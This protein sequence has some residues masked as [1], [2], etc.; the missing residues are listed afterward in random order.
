MA[1][2]A[3]IGYALVYAIASLVMFI[4]DV[5]WTASVFTG[6]TA[7]ALAAQKIGHRFDKFFNDVFDRVVNYRRS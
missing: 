6:A 7:V 4:F 1:L 3:G 5:T 2:G